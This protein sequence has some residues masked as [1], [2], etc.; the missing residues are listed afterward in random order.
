MSTDPLDAVGQVIDEKYA[1]ERFVAQGGFSYVYLAR[2]KI[3]HQAVAIKFLKSAGNA[4]PS[5]RA[6][7]LKAFL[8]EGALLRE[9]SSRTACIL[10]AHD[11]GGRTA[12]DGTWYPF[13]VLEWLDGE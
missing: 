1:V 13:L 10:Q 4:R 12:S 8:Q 7:L 3:W 11:V 6:E 2:H 9:M 5:E